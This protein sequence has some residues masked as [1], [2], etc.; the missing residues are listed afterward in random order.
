M[1]LPPAK[2]ETDEVICQCFQVNESTI[3]EAIEKDNLTEID[4]VTEN[5]EA[6]GGCHSCHILLQLFID[7]HQQKITPMENLV[8]DHGQKV[9]KRGILSRFFEKVNPASS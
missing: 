1:N 6:G 7:E 3:R 9:K 2:T 4:Q 5:C 8:H